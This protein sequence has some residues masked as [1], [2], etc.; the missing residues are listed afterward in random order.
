[1]AGSHDRGTGTSRRADLLARLEAASAPPSEATTP[2]DVATAI[3]ARS[4]N[5]LEA[6]AGFVAT[7]SADGE[8]LEVARVTPF[9]QEPVR[10]S[11][12]LD[13]PYPLAETI[14]TRR[15]LFIASNEALECDHPG[16]VRVQGEDHACATM[17]LHADDGELL[18]AL[19]LGFEDPHEFTD[20]ERELIELVAARC[21]EAMARARAA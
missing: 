2:G 17:P 10:L 21:A 5:V 6:D 9:A 4:L 1:M 12:P 19:N 3:V 7:V 18:G 20:E 14:R 16:L 11:F 13:A 8:T 15:P